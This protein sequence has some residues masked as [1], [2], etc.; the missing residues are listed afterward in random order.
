MDIEE[1][2]LKK[3]CKH[4]FE[5][6]QIDG[7]ENAWCKKCH[8]LYSEYTKREMAKLEKLQANPKVKEYGECL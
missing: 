6:D 4:E 1:K 5:E 7:F 8:M 2:Q 3:E